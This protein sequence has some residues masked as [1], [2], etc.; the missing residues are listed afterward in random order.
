[1]K[2]NINHTV[3]VRLTD[4]GRQIHQDNFYELFGG[5]PNAIIPYRPPA[6]DKDGW[7]EWQLWHLME[8]FGP[9]VGLGGLTP[10]ETEIDVAIF[11]PHD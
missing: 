2:F 5:K 4:K 3:K 1:M 8:E 7:S 10:F 9:H 6:E 11:L